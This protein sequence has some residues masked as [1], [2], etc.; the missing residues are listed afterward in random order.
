MVVRVN[1]QGFHPKNVTVQK[2]S[3]TQNWCTIAILI[4]VYVT[5]LR[6]NESFSKFTSQGQSVLWTWKDSGEEAHNI[7]HVNT[8]ESEVRWSVIEFGDPVIKFWWS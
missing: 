8:P 2:V 7:V 4:A 5:L 3:Q 1:S 6:E